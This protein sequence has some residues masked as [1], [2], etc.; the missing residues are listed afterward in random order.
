LAVDE[1]VADPNFFVLYGDSY[2][3]IRLYDVETAYSMEIA[4]VLMTVYRDRD[5]R[6]RPN[7]V[8]DGVM[9]RRYQKGLER[10]PDE[11]QFVDYGLS[12]WQRDVVD[13]LVPKDAVADLADLFTEL[14]ESGRLAG[15]EAPERFYEIGSP[16]GLRDLESRL[17]TGGALATPPDSGH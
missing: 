11:M 9:V 6:E 13:S 5:G 12:V 1:G 10:A 2:L 7:A 14:S 16:E 3:P 4:P 8:F 15:F 17:Q